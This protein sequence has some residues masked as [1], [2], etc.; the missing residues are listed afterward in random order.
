M[1]WKQEVVSD[2]NNNNKRCANKSLSQYFIV[3]SCTHKLTTFSY[4]QMAYFGERALECGP[5]IF[6]EE[7]I[8]WYQFPSGW[9]LVFSNI[10]HLHCFRSPASC[11]LPACLPVSHSSVII[12][13]LFLIHHVR[14]TEYG[15]R[16]DG[17][18]FKAIIMIKMFQTETQ[19]ETEHK[20]RGGKDL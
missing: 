4:F 17:W 6:L 1:S 12:V 7:Q 9:L 18:W 3:I 11:S 14:S 15:I 5:L 8:V 2:S 10:S 19:H 20:P 13:K 16:T